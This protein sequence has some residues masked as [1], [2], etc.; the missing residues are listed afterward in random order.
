MYKK[1][2]FD[3]F[4][5]IEELIQKYYDFEVTASKCKQCPGYKKRWS[6]PDFDFSPT[7]FLHGFSSFHFIVDRV[8]NEGTNTV[9]E[10]Q[11]RLFEEKRFFDQEMRK[12]E[13]ASPGSYALVAQECVQCKR[14]SRLSGL[15]CVY[16]QI[17]RYGPEA[18]GIL[19]VKL[20]YDKF[21]F[22]VQWSDGVSIPDYYVLAGGVLLP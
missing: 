7:L 19:A 16:P 11:N 3:A 21:H 18:I 13:M 17:M 8:S 10:A 4:L 22:M 12:T 20:I 5:S 2:R 15:Q 9:E 6:C 1:E 14:C